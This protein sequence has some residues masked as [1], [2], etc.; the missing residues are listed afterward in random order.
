MISQKEIN[1]MFEKEKEQ[2]EKDKEK[3][4]QP[5]LFWERKHIYSTSCNIW[6]T[7][8]EP[9]KWLNNYEYRR[10]EYQNISKIS[11]KICKT[12][13]FED[14]IFYKLNCGCG[15]DDYLEFEYVYSNFTNHSKLKF[16]KKLVWVDYYYT[17]NIFTRFIKR[18]KACFSIIFKGRLTI[19]DEF[20]ISNKD[21]LDDFIN[22]LQEG[23]KKFIEDSKQ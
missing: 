10:I 20:L 15:C 22:A 4:K 13:E 3:Y 19:N 8:T 1:I 5:W 11:T 21:Q 23:K 6:L 16:Y 18:I 12:H 2:Y 7:C 9:I 17:D 14:S